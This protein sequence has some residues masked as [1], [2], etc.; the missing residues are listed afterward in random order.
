MQSVEN[1]YSL[2]LKAEGLTLYRGWSDDVARQLVERSQESEIKKFTKRDAVERFIDEQAANEWYRA[3]EHVVY[4]L[5]QGDELAGVAWFAHTERPEL[6]ADYTFAI[7]MYESQRGRGLAGA[8]I[9]SVHEDF[10]A[11]K[12]YAGSFWLESDESNE[13]AVHFYQ[14]HAY[15]LLGVKDGRVLMV[16]KGS[17]QE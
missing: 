2:P 17:S 13:R 14:K 16:R 12:D 15:R 9:E 11:Y 6:S 10:A 8:L 4:T 3:K 5:F 1:S 7:R